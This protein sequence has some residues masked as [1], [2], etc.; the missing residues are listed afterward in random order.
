MGLSRQEYWSGLPF[1]S[2]EDLLFLLNS[3]RRKW[4]PTPI[5]LPG[6]PRGQRSLVGSG[7]WGRLQR[8]SRRGQ[9]PSATWGG[10]VQRWHRGLASPSPV[11]S[12]PPT[13]FLIP[14][15]Q[16]A[17]PRLL[18]QF[19]GWHLMQVC[20]GG[21]G[22]G[23]TVSGQYARTLISPTLLTALVLLYLGVYAFVFWI[24]ICLFLP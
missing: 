16:Q 13:A 6:E 18:G 17:R 24:F 8:P 10:M 19:S 7:P 4:Q 9:G 1:P 20:L 22:D 21:G 5:F 2:P 15:R 23:L 11:P 3:V 12:P 14:R